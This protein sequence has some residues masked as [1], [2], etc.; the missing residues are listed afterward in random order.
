VTNVSK[1]EP[2]LYRIE[3]TQPMFVREEPSEAD[4]AAA[5]KA[6]ADKAA[7]D[8]AVAADA[9][10]AKAAAAADPDKAKA[11]EAKLKADLQARD[12]QLAELN[13]TLESLQSGLSSTLK[14][15]GVESVEQLE[16]ARADRER[17]D[18]ER[19]GEYDR[20]VE[21]MKTR[22][23]AA[24]TELTTEVGTLKEQLAAANA[25]LEELTIGR[26]FSDSEFISKESAIPL[27]IARNLFLG[28]F[29]RSDSG[30]VAYDK[31]AGAA[32]R[33]P[34]VDAEG[35]PLSFDAAIGELYAK[36]PESKS[37]LKSKMKPGPGSRTTEDLKTPDLDKQEVR[38]HSRILG[39]LNAKK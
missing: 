23:E 10:A 21:Q 31:P 14:E 36:H 38:G 35:K 24:T 13:K 8:K 9:A 3:Q 1:A 2:F 18:L 15:L 12:S 20:I 28:H 25:Q 7:A 32:D 19:K 11:A 29:E 34:L 37:L 33:T 6:A 22:A 26:S 4:K 16:Q 27:S 30:V 39:A 17:Q 5:D